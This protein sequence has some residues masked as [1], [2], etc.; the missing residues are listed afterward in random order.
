MAMS[1][2]ERFRLLRFALAFSGCV[3]GVSACGVFMKWETVAGALQGMGAKPISYDPMLDYWLRMAS[4]AFALLGTGY[5]LLAV[6]PAKFAGM[7]PWFGWIMVL[8][9]IV[10]L[11]HGLRLGLS[12]F[13]FAGDVCASL[14]G[15]FGIL[16]F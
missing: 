9:G 6:N 16:V 8:E 3:W 7:L 12:P 4:A 11:S 1:T 10:L 2:A 13:P 15:G 14:A 5:F